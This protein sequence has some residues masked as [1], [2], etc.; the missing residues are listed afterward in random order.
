MDAFS[1]KFQIFGQTTDVHTNTASC[2]GV[3]DKKYIFLFKRCAQNARNGI[4]D[5]LKADFCYLQYFTAL[6]LHDQFVNHSL[7]THA[8]QNCLDMQH[9]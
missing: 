6:F 3:S 4:R 2:P 7:Q 5:T 9:A 8:Y 1:H